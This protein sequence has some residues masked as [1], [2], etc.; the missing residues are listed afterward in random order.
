MNKTITII[1]CGW[2]GLELG[3]ALVKKNFKVKGTT[4]NKEKLETLG[5]HGIKGSVL[6]LGHKFDGNWGDLLQTD[7]VVV[8][9]PPSISPQNPELP[10]RQIRDA[11]SHS[12][13]QRVIYTSATSVYPSHNSTVTEKD[14]KYIESPH[15][16]TVM[17]DL[18]DV[19][20][21][22]DGFDT[23][24]LRLAGLVGGDRLP[25]KSRA[26]K[27]VKNGGAPMNLV[28]RSDVINAIEAVINQ[29]YFGDVFNV[30]A[31]AHPTRKEF[32]T[33]VAQKLNLEL[34]VFEDNE[35]GDFKI[36]SNEKIKKE[37]GV[38]FGEILRESDFKETA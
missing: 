2:L 4:T 29:D 17:L 10:L 35:K 7:V 3:K 32:Y 8:D 15:S 33:T 21:D 26:G 14:A 9:I 34:P 19:F 5:S 12:K 18:E 13:C 20:T 22:S 36:V 25:G 30:C 16:G 1:G 31:D 24:V 28:H 38:K 6:S 11:I 27:S 37:I 23:T